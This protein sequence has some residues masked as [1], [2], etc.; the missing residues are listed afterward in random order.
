ME[1][2]FRYANQA[3]T[4]NG[5][6]GGVVVHG[7]RREAKHLLSRCR[8]QAHEKGQQST[9]QTVRHKRKGHRRKITTDCQI[10]AKFSNEFEFDYMFF[11]DESLFSVYLF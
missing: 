11:V 1:V 7:R 5:F 10:L 8:G 4:A 3:V 9:D 2:V 6:T